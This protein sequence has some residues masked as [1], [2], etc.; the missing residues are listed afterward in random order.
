[1]DEN[2]PHDPTVQIWIHERALFAFIIAMVVLGSVI[3]VPTAYLRWKHKRLKEVEVG[4]IVAGYLLFL[5][6]QIL[7]LKIQPIIYRQSLVGLGRMAP[8]PT[9]LD[10]R[11]TVVTLTIV[12]VI[13]FVTCLWCIKISLLFFI[14]Q[15]IKGLP[16]EMRWWAVIMTYT[17]VTWLFCFFI[18]LFSCGGPAAFSRHHLRYCQKPIES[19]TRNT[20]LFGCF[21]S[22]VSTDLLIM[23]LPVRLI[24]NLRISRARKFAA[25]AM[26]SVGVLCMI[27]SIIRLVQIGSKTGVQNPNVQWISLWGSIEATTV[28][29]LPTF[30]F[31]RKTSNPSA[32]GPANKGR[33][34]VSPG[35]R[36]HPSREQGVPDIPLNTYKPPENTPQMYNVI[37]SSMESFTPTGK[38]TLSAVNSREASAR[39]V[40]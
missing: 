24:F 7:L 1:M 26:F 25:A 10:E 27:T 21:A 14:R 18:T 32:A 23:I 16:D 22:D 39:S 38:A 15:V 35:S 11:K 34:D 13:V 36:E 19:I 31:F 40:V 29:C 30:R 20:S 5:A 17:V 3:L 4:L 6:Y 2:R 8:Y 33:A 37:F 28:G 12:S 9:I